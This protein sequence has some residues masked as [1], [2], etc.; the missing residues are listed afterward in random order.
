MAGKASEDAWVA[1]VDGCPTGWLVVFARSPSAE[2]RPPRI[3]PRFADILAAPEKPRIVAVDIP[4][5]LPE[6]SEIR[7]RGP[8][9]VVR[10]L[11]GMRRSSVFRVP[12][13]KAVAAGVDASISDDRER[14]LAS[15]AIAR[16]TSSDE[17][18]FGKQ[19]FYLFPKIVEV[20]TL[21]RAH[22]QPNGRFFE[23]HPELAFWR[24]NAD[25]VLDEPKK[26]K[27]RCHEPGL[28]LRRRLL[29]EAGFPATVVKGDPPMGAGPDDLLD[30]L[31]CAA[32]ARRIHAKCARP[33]PDPFEP[34]AFGLRM[35]IWA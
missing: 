29:I 27:G 13:R 24:L 11:L 23:V 32:I 34:D 35:A 30:A 18:A 9:R 5:G 26:R 22:K 17:K 12:S 4:I 6:H 1:G 15:C 14:Y 31:A 20:D 33:F 2:V 16:A 8:E 28:A 25:H 19:S 3:M 10:P 7:G 21:L